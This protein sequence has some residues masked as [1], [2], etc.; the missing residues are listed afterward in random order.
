MRHEQ[1]SCFPME[2]MLGGCNDLGCVP[3]VVCAQPYIKQ[4]NWQ[5]FIAPPVTLYGDYYFV[6]VF[7]PI[8]LPAH[9]AQTE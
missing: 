8:W 5:N 9:T 7:S 4:G 3:S 1:R 2:P 6:A